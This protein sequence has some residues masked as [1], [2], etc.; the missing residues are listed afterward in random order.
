HRAWRDLTRERCKAV[1][2]VRVEIEAARPEAVSR[3]IESE[4]LAHDAEADDADVAGGRQHGAIVRLSHAGRADQP[5]VRGFSSLPS[6]GWPVIR[7][8]CRALWCR[9]CFRVSFRAVRAGLCPSRAAAN[10]AW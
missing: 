9:S 1:A 5:G 3:K 6:C 4:V 10:A 8:A 2:L 7:R